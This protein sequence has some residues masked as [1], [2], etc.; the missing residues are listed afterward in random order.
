MPATATGAQQRADYIRKNLDAL[1]R[2]I[3]AM[4]SRLARAYKLED[5]RALGHASWAD[6]CQQEYGTHMAKLAAGVRQAWRPT[7]EAAGMSTGEIAA[8]CGVDRKTIQRDS[9][10]RP[11]LPAATNVAADQDQQDEDQDQEDEQESEGRTTR[12]ATSSTTSAT[13][14]ATKPAAASKPKPTVPSL[15]KALN[16]LHDAMDTVKEV[17]DEMALLSDSEDLSDWLRDQADELDTGWTPSDGNGLEA[18]N[19]QANRL[20]YAAADVYAKAAVIRARMAE[21]GWV[22]D[23]G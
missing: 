16:N 9:K 14:P 11:A 5:W 18:L 15:D 19:H 20:E 22:A 6:Y 23:E 7:L 12:Q 17:L 2:D 10:P 4:A 8:A 3:T 1:T 21:A 13:K